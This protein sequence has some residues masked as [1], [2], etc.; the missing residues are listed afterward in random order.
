[1]AE[2]EMTGGPGL[3]GSSV[4]AGSCVLAG[5]RQSLPQALTV[6]RTS[7][8]PCASVRGGETLVREDRDFAR[9]AEAVRERLRSSPSKITE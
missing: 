2:R 1:M 4:G 8:V 7:N 6:S 9:K 3:A 5:L